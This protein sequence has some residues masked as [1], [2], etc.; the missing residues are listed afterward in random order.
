V[1]PVQQDDRAFIGVG[2]I[3][4]STSDTARTMQTAAAVLQSRMI[5]ARAAQD[6]GREWTP[7]EVDNAVAIEVAGESYILDVRAKAQ[8]DAD[9][10]RVA[11]TF[12]RSALLVRDETVRE[13]VARLIPR[14]RAQQ[15]EV[16]AS[17]AAPS[18][19]AEIAARISQLQS[20][21]LDDDPTVSLQ[22]PAY[23]ASL[24]GPSR[25]LVLG[26]GLM[27]GLALGAVAAILL[28]LTGRRIRDAEEAMELFPLPVLARV[29]RLSAR[30]AKE[31]SDGMRVID[32]AVYEAFRGVFLELDDGGEA[33]RAVMLTSASTGDGTTTSALYLA[34]SMALAGED[35]ILID[36]DLRSPSLHRILAL[37]GDVP[38]LAAT[39]DAPL[40]DLLVSMHDVPLSLL[41]AGVAASSPQVTMLIAR[42]PDLVAEARARVDF[43]VIDTP[44]LGEVSDSIPLLR[45]VDDVV[46][47]TR[48]RHTERTAY[49]AMRDVILRTGAN[50]RGMVIID[51]GRDNAKVDGRS[52]DA[53]DPT[54]RRFPLRRDAGTR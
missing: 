39:P 6:L 52:N 15:R 21:A 25:V 33:G 45:L 38:T 20:T 27:A 24:L 30:A 41:S 23:S 36:C 22:E 46:V 53:R 34:L 43:V 8:S 47:V 40:D 42:L 14:L 28:E 2:V 44:P 17:P 13:Q 7:A 9:A 48:P 51:E 50:P 4:E 26:L 37:D 12:A 5:A 31:A 1:S 54:P 16:E 32:Q 3:R 49:E 29:P 19:A 18:A 35:V 10:V 11:N